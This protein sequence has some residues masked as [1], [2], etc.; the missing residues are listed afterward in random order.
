LDCFE[1][2]IEKV[3]PRLLAD[4]IYALGITYKSKCTHIFNGFEYHEDLHVQAVAKEALTE[5]SKS[6]DNK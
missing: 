5:L 1:D 4:A 3:E 2:N 6:N